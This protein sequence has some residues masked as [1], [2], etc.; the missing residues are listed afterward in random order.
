MSVL[1]FVDHIDGHIKKASHE[2][3]SYGAKIAEQTGTTAEAVILGTVN[4]DLEKL[5]EHGVKKVYQVQNE[6][7][8]QFDSQ[9]YTKVIAQVAQQSGAKVI[10]FSNNSS[11]KALAPRVAVRLKAGLAAGVNALPDTSNGFTVRKTVFS[12]K[13]FA[14]VAIDTEIKVLSLNVNA[15][16]IIT[17]EGKA[18]VIPFDAIVESPKLKTIDSTKTSGKVSLTE[19]DVVVSAGRGLKGPENWGMVEELAD[20]LGA[21]LA[22]SRPVADA[23]WRPHNEHVGQTG[24][25]IAPNLYVAVGISGAIQHLAG[26][27][28]SKVIVVINKDPEAP[29]FKAADYGVVGDAFEIVPKLTSAIKKLKGQS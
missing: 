1:I 21:A 9:V 20:T 11:G 10:I 8:Q 14:Q 7:L 19:A 3:L 2:A 29:F 26:V 16:T 13:A 17:G 27:N 4:D 12:G 24:I 18:E 25:A 22:C 23:H 6:Q 28:R 15:F 5:G